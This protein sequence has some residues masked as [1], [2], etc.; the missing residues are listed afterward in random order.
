M[1]DRPQLTTTADAERDMRGFVLKSCTEGN[2]DL[3][4]GSS[5][6]S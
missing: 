6:K 2:W 5:R 3:V 1:V 4:G